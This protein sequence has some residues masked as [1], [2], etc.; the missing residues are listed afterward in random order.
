MKHLFALT[1]LLVTACSR[2]DE[3]PAPAAAEPPL[4]RLFADVTDGRLRIYDEDG[5]VVRENEEVGEDARVV[6]RRGFVAVFTGE[7]A[8]GLKLYNYRG[9]PLLGGQTVAFENGARGNFGISDRIFAYVTK[10]E[11]IA[12][13]TGGKR[14][15]TGPHRPDDKT[16][17]H[18]S[19]NIVAFTTHV[20]DGD[21]D[22][23]RR[24][25]AFTRQGR[26]LGTYGQ[27]LNEQSAVFISD[28]LVGMTATLSEADKLTKEE[29]GIQTWSTKPI[30]ERLFTYTDDG[31]ELGTSAE[32]IDDQTEITF[33]S[34]FVIMNVPRFREGKLL[35]EDGNRKTFE[36]IPDGR[37]NKV[38]RFDGR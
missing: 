32:L 13:D 36:M 26:Q 38:F 17:L 8:T 25:S 28:H 19:E 7:N 22:L 3:A 29:N 23:G 24:L 11:V 4:K 34:R 30:G 14:I 2:K 5:R 1:L 20:R 21:K 33:H 10:D 27:I 12:V 35:S 18:V 31:R 37:A 16:E 9:E 15:A 6:V